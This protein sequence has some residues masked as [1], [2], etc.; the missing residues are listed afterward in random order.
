ML[1]IELCQNVRTVILYNTYSVIQLLLNSNNIENIN[2]SFLLKI[3]Y[4]CFKILAMSKIQEDRVCRTC[5]MESNSMVNIS[6]FLD[7]SLT[8]AGAIQEFAAINV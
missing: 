2:I 4:F 6:D 1:V 7:D 3:N 5:L 8:I